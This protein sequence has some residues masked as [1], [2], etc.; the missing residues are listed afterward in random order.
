MSAAGEEGLD[1]ILVEAVVL[2]HSVE[3]LQI[4]NVTLECDLLLPATCRTQIVRR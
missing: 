4:L 3:L 2:Q 1:V